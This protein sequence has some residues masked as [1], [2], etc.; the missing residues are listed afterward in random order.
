MVTTQKKRPAGRDERHSAAWGKR[1]SAVLFVVLATG[2]AF[3]QRFDRASTGRF[4]RIAPELSGLLSN[5]KRGTTKGQTVRV[6]VQYKQRP[7]SAH[8]AAM[9]GRGARLHTKLHMINAAAFTIP[10]SALP[11]LEADPAIASVTIDHP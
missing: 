7:T 1:L 10:V 11:A 6:I 5:A 2:M 9:N 3:G 8:Y 4:S